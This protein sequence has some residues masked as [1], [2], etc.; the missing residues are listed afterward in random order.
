MNA[1]TFIPAG[2]TSSYQAPIADA[3]TPVGERFA[4]PNTVAKRIEKQRRDD[5]FK[6]KLSREFD[7]IDVNRDGYLERAELHQYFLERGVDD[8]EQRAKIVD[9]VIENCDVDH[10]DR[11]SK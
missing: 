10:D 1:N 7:G 9:T 6:D 5:N 8:P 11:I 2:A 3:R 4:N